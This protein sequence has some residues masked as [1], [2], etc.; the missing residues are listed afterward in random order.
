M[1]GEEVNLLFQKDQ[2]EG[3]KN[4]G[5]LRL[6]IQLSVILYSMHTLYFVPFLGM[7]PLKKCALPPSFFHCLPLADHQGRLQEFGAPVR[8]GIWGPMLNST[9]TYFCTII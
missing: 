4:V 9:K 8:N 1:Q 6:P 3:F 5:L 2:H 7:K